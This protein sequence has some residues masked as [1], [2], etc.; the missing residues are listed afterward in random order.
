MLFSRHISKRGVVFASAFASVFSLAH[1]VIQIIVY[2]QG[3]HGPMFLSSLLVSLGIFAACL[4]IMISFIKDKKNVALITTVIAMP[5]Y[6]TAIFFANVDGFIDGTYA[7]MEFWPLGL[8]FIE[9]LVVAL[10]VIESFVYVIIKFVKG[11]G[12]PKFSPAQNTEV[13]CYILLFVEV[14]W[15]IGVIKYSTYNNISYWGTICG[16]IGE[17]SMLEAFAYTLYLGNEKDE[18]VPG[19]IKKPENP[20]EK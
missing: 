8:C 2:A 11:K 6:G 18:A 12:N 14:L 19:Q 4:I 3:S 5:L 9:Y 20:E 7:A 15:V 16:Y 13:A 10:T 1:A 17:V